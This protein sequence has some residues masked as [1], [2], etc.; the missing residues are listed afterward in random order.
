MSMYTHE[1]CICLYVVYAYCIHRVSYAHT[2]IYAYVLI[3]KCIP[4]NRTGL[5]THD[6]K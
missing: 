6:T 3:Y 4:V 1:R 5:G 2:H